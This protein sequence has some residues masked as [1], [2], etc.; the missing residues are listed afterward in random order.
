MWEF[1]EDWFS[2]LQHQIEMRLSRLVRDV[3]SSVTDIAPAAR[4]PVDIGNSLLGSATP[5]VAVVAPKPI[6]PNSYSLS[7]QPGL[8]GNKEE[9]NSF[10]LSSHPDLF[11]NDKSP[12]HVVVDNSEDLKATPRSSGAR[13]NLSSLWD[14]L[15]GMHS[16]EY[17]NAHPEMFD[18]PTF[19]VAPPVRET[20]SQRAGTWISAGGRMLQWASGRLRQSS[21]PG[22]QMAA[23]MAGR[24]GSLMQ[25]VGGA[26]SAGGPAAAAA[27]TAAAV[28]GIPMAVGSFIAA[29]KKMGEGLLDSQRQLAMF[30]G[31]IATTLAMTDVH[32]MRM[33]MRLAS[34]TADS[35]AAL[36]KSMRELREAVQPLKEVFYTLGIEVANVVVKIAG[37]TVNAP[38]NVANWLVDDVGLNAGPLGIM[39]QMLRAKG[40]Q[41]PVSGPGQDFMQALGRQKAA[42]RPPLRPIP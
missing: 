37:A 38:A 29:T 35:T 24:T 27:G 34:A 18:S 11:G 13:E 14:R 39:W 9:S 30:N 3:N 1:L 16:P 41:A 19:D 33:D 2:Q 36:G 21:I 7:S 5:P 32:R 25:T 4:S 10:P 28:I 6:N 26:M 12:V 23:S 20:R 31:S 15:L 8:F 22:S 40:K 42:P 17:Q